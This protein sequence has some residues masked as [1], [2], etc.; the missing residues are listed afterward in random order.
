[1]ASNVVVL[2]N[3]VKRLPI[4]TTPMMPLKEIAKLAC[5]KQGYTDVENYGLKQNK[6][7]LD[8]SLSVRFA[9]LAP[10]AKLELIRVNTPKAP[11]E[12]SIALQ[13]DD[14]GRIIGKFLSSTTLWEILLHF[15]NTSQDKS[16]NL[17][18]RTAPVPVSQSKKGMWKKIKPNNKLFYQEPVCI[19][20][21]KEYGN[22]TLLKSTSL[23]SAGITSGNV[24]L[25]LLFRHTEL[26]LDDVLEEINAPVKS[27]TETSPVNE[28]NSEKPVQPTI[29]SVIS[30]VLSTPTVKQTE[31]TITQVN[32]LES[33]EGTKMT[34]LVE[35]KETNIPVNSVE[36]A[37]E[38]N[39]QNSEETVELKSEIP[40]SQ[41]QK[42]DEMDI[43]TKSLNVHDSTVEKMDIDTKSPDVHDS[44]DKKMDI[45]TKSPDI[46]DST[47]KKMDIDTK[48]PDVHDSTVK[49]LEDQESIEKINITH[50]ETAQTSSNTNMC[51]SIEGNF[52]RDVKV[53]NPPAENVTLL[54]QIDL[55]DS[56][57]ELTPSELQYLLAMQNSQRKAKENAV[58]KTRAVREQ[59]EKARER[60]YPKT[61][62]RVRFPDSFQLQMN[63]LSKETV[64]QL[65]EFVKGAL[66]TP[67]RSFHLY[68][69]PPK[70][71][72]ADMSVSLYHA[73]LA[74][75]TIVHFNWTDKLS[76]SGHFLSDE[77]LKLRIDLPHQIVDSSITNI[78]PE[79]SSSISNE[80]GHVLSE[81]S[82]QQNL[83]QEHHS[84]VRSLSSKVPKWFKFNKK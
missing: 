74:P 41:S 55:P 59:E 76:D 40:S 30:P 37:E 69:S 33:T 61:M 63:F 6:K 17:T 83:G 43:D 19:L 67:Q 1:M 53:F 11:S 5:D 60:K 47:D 66:R 79:Q 56:F 77:Y 58:F 8:L 62:I 9:N 16:L 21:N 46:H 12:V 49:S 32:S 73:G 48:S 7:N 20:L 45:D 70:N 38:I 65:Y 78:V 29:P 36:S 84:R 24:L 26:S 14:G 75:A 82:R 80:G 72:I 68:T 31:E 35:S 42:V 51:E 50:V 13:M 52:D 57:Y 22:I 15:E 81:P 18:R 27:S 71:V 2:I 23:Q 34:N 44:T 25:R 4:K 39:I 54:T 3:G 64:G 28:N 10:G